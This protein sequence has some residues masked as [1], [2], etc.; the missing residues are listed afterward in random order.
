[1]RGRFC[2][3]K[4]PAGKTRIFLPVTLTPSTACSALG[5]TTCAWAYPSTLRRTPHLHRSVHPTLRSTPLLHCD[6]INPPL[7]CDTVY[8]LLH[9][10]R[11]TPSCTA[12]AK[13]TLHFF[14]FFPKCGGTPQRPFYLVLVCLLFVQVQGVRPN[15]L[16]ICFWDQPRLRDFAGK[17]WRPWTLWFECCWFELNGSGI[18]LEALDTLV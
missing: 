7:H 10:L 6:A 15:A 14:F 1:M 3:A 11:P 2:A 5:R 18:I 8:P 12:F 9:C 17:L 13:C 4:L 16:F